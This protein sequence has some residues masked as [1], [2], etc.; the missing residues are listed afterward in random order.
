MTINSVAQD[1]A[2]AG[3]ANSLLRDE[4]LFLISPLHPFNQISPMF[5]CFLVIKKSFA[6]WRRHFFQ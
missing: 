3:Y 2:D 4:V 1:I 6:D 5:S